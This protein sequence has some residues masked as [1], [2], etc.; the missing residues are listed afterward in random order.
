MQY[1]FAIGLVRIS[2]YNWKEKKKKCIIVQ[3]FR[4]RADKDIA[5]ISSPV[6]G[7]EKERS[8][9][10]HFVPMCFSVCST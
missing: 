5:G 3:S 10:T 1:A 8:F 6:M 7:R 9:F 4:C 2:R